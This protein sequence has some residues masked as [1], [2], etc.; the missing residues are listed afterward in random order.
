MS[1]FRPTVVKMPK[2]KGFSSAGSY[3][4]QE[5]IILYTNFI[6]PLIA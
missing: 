3:S 2:R 6:L 5:D 4:L 1:D